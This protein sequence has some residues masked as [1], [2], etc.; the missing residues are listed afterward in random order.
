MS[1]HFSLDVEEAELEVLRGLN[2]NKYRPK[3]ILVEIRHFKVIDGFLTTHGYC[4][5]QVEKM[6][7][8]DFLYKDKAEGKWIRK[9][10]KL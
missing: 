9:G 2:L 8:H 3:F 4:D 6:S 5:S 1:E 10:K 7:Y